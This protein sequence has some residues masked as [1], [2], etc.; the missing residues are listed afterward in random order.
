M[1]HIV[2]YKLPL[3]PPRN[4]NQEYISQG[5][6]KNRPE[7]SH[8]FMSALLNSGCLV[9]CWDTNTTVFPTISHTLPFSVGYDQG[10]EVVEHHTSQSHHSYSD[11]CPISQVVFVPPYIGIC[12]F[13]CCSG[14]Y[15]GFLTPSLDFPPHPPSSES[16]GTSI[17]VSHV[18]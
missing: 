14:A 8:F 9:S 18:Q 13:K 4:A 6:L 16:L 12:I 15:P 7:V 2:L 1:I 3:L 10:H 11:I 5:L 17:N